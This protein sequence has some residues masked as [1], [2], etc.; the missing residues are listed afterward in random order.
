LSQKSA[1]VLKARDKRSAISGITAPLPLRIFDN[2]F[3]E[4][5]RTDANSLIVT[6]NYPLAG[7]KERFFDIIRKV[8]RYPAMYPWTKI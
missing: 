8:G 2:V 7:T 6:A 4:T 5:P 1:V 3:L